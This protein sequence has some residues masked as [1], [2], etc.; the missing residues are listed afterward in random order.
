MNTYTD[1]HLNS[2]LSI[3]VDSPIDMIQMAFK[4]GYS[5]VCFA[6]FNNFPFKK[7]QEFKKNITTEVKV[8]TRIDIIGENVRAIKQRLQNI[9]PYID[10]IG[11]KCEKK[12]I[13]N[14]ALQDSRIDL[15]TFFNY[16]NFYLLT[17]EAAKLATRNL[18]AIEIFVR[19]LILN[20]GLN[21]SKLIRL[22]RKSVHNI[23][24]AKTPF[25]ITSGAQS[26]YEMRA[27]RELITLMGLAD[28]PKELCK[29]AVSTYPIKIIQNRGLGY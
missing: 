12:A 18:K 25:V 13:F 3:G 8:L 24:R 16:S 5:Y 1:L 29:K 27:P 4:L 7:I 11:L 28:L 10:I 14:W 15:L 20:T 9:R 2:N 26:I 6:D 19:P 17:Y 22:L 23:V 21:R